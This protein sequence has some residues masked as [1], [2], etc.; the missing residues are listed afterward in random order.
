MAPASSAVIKKLVDRYLDNACYAVIEG[1]IEIAG[2]ICNYQWDLICFTGSTQKGKLVAEAAGRNLIPCILELGG[3]CPA[4]V[5][6]SADVDFAASKVAN[7]RFSNSGQTCLSTDYV[8]VH[9][10]LKNQFV[11]ALQRHANSMF[12]TSATGSPDMGKVITDWHCDRLKKMID[13]SKGKVVCGGKVNRGIKYVE[14]TV[15][16]N[17]DL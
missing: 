9:E 10:S 2:K 3:K 17:P 12:G 1:G 14:P 13:T 5:D 4:V 16:E 11:E 6:V 7:A 8:I 15:I